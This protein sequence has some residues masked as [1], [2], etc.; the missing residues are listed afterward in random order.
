MTSAGSFKDGGWVLWAWRSYAVVLLL[1]GFSLM[2]GGTVLASNGGSPYY[3]I[4]GLLVATS[5]FLIWR[6][7]RRGAALFGVML[8]GTLGWAVWEVGANTW[9][10]VAR[11]VAP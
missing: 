2:A 9:G 8:V 3:V 6:G 11:L 4:A 10:L 5:G 7:D 1:I